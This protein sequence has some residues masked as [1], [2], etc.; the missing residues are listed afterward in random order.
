[1]FTILSKPNCPHCTSAKQALVFKKLDYEEIIY[2]TNEKQNAFI[3]R[4]FRTFPQVFH[5]EKHIGGSN[6][7]Q[8]YLIDNY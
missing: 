6:E 5:D 3:E 2:D 1:M 7:L 8:M 4:G